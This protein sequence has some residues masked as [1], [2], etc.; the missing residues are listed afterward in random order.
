MALLKTVSPENAE[1][2]LAELYSQTEQMFGAVPNNVRMYGVS[3][4]I[5]E[6]QLQLIEHYMGHP[7]LGFPFL[8]T[9]RMLVAEASDS[10]YCSAFNAMILDRAGVS[11]EKLEAVKADP[12]NAEMTD[13]EKALLVFVLKA[14]RQPHSV[15]AED[16]DGLKSMGWSE[17]D[18][19]DAVAHGARA[20][21]T[22]IIFDTFKVEYD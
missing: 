9:L 13:K 20:V 16:V 3:P 17:V 4:P 7:S 2:K 12:Q 10:P 18:I 22:N 8:A 11:P 6:N 1:G 14:T 21:S 5:L 15:T 19:F